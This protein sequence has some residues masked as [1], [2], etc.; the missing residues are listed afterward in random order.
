MPVLLNITNEEHSHSHVIFILCYFILFVFF[1]IIIL[2]LFIFL[3]FWISFRFEVLSIWFLTGCVYLI[4]PPPYIHG[5]SFL[6]KSAL[7][8]TRVLPG[9]G[10]CFN[11]LFSEEEPG[12]RG[13]CAVSG[14]A[15]QRLMCTWVLVL[16]YVTLTDHCLT[17]PNLA[18][19]PSHFREENKWR[20]TAIIF[21]FFFSSFQL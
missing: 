6:T 14:T 7:K 9:G 21:M 13:Q 12:L 2:L 20:V 19:S 4:N 3:L 10:Q 8:Y 18:G 5:L 16:S 15:V 1:I 11:A 17:L